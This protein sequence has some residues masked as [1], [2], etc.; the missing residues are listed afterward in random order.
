M[1]KFHLTYF[2]IC[3]SLFTINKIAEVAMMN[4]NQ[5]QFSMLNRDDD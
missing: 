4:R 1:K 2:I 5:Q 3:D